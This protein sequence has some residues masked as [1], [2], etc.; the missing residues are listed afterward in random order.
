MLDRL[1]HHSNATSLMLDLF[2]ADLPEDQEIYVRV[3]DAL[4]SVP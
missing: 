3:A 2:S 4:M 1:D